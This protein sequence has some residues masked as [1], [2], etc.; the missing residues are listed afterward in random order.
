MKYL[1]IVTAVVRALSNDNMGG[2]M[3]FEPRVQDTKLKG[4]IT[5]KDDQLL[6][7]SMIRARLHSSLAPEHWEILK[8]KFSPDIDDKRESIRAVRTRVKTPAPNRFRDAAV[9][10]WAMP[11]LPGKDGKRS[12]STLPA[13][14]YDLDRW[15]DEPVPARTQ[16]RWR[17]TIA[18][19]LEA[20][21]NK[22]LAIAQEALEPLGVFQGVAA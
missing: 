20:E 10:T 22:A 17:K 4:E 19:G 5:G 13:E 7:D 16:Q 15:C 12:V 21:V 3:N 2:G 14:W 11:K 1:N 6:H 9:L 8:A 18:D